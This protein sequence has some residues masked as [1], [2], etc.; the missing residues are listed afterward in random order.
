MT[1]RR[2]SRIKLFSQVIIWDTNKCIKKDTNKCIKKECLMDL[3]EG[4]LNV[5]HDHLMMFCSKSVKFEH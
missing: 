3:N 2:I 4:V 1:V 5:N